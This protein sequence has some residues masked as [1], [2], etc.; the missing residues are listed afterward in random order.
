MKRIVLAGG[1]LAA[2]AGCTTGQP[3]TGVEAGPT[4]MAT[5]SA[6]EPIPAAVP[7][8]DNI[9]LADWTG[10]YDGVPPWDKVRPEQFSEAFQFAIGEQRSEMLAI[11]N[12]PQPATFAN[13]IEAMEK[14][15]RR[16]D[17]VNSIFGV[18]TDNISTPQIQEIDKEWSPKLSAAYDEIVLNP[19]LFQR[20]SALYEARPTLGLTAVQNRL[21]ER[22]YDSFVRRGAKLSAEQKTQLS[23]MNQELASAFSDFNALLLNDE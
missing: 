8:P 21:L 16:L 12:N 7:V 17:R 4:A 13:T 22:T 15:G 3:Y 19:K 14:A 2:L 5:E 11:A 23:Q 1:A 9:L 10:P 6:V 20:V 18:Y